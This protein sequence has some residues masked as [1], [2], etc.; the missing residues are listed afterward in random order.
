MSSSMEC[1]NWCRTTEH[2][3][4]GNRKSGMTK[5]QETFNTRPD[6]KQ[7]FHHSFVSFDICRHSLWPHGNASAFRLVSRHLESSSALS[8][9]A[10]MR[11]G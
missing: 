4:D 3:A 11:E 1:A 5:D 6:D 9:V 2:R 8:G 7:S 10:Q